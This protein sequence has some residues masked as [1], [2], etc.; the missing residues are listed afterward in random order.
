LNTSKCLEFGSY[1]QT[2]ET[3]DNKMILR[4]LYYI[5]LVT[6]MGVNILRPFVRK[7][8]QSLKFGKNSM[9]EGFSRCVHELAVIDTGRQ[10]LSVRE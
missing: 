8:N 5:L 6:W 4:P 1:F 7:T 3:N 10:G 2:H 9:P